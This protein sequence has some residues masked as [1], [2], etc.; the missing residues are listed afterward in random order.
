ME[1][2]LEVREAVELLKSACFDTNCNDC[3]Y[4]YDEGKCRLSLPIAK[5]PWYW[6]TGNST[7]TN[8]EDV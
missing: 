7:L 4:T 6:N 3:P 1:I 2:I 8:E 5:E